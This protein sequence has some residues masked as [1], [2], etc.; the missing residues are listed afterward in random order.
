M[1]ITALFLA[2]MDLPNNNNLEKF[3]QTAFYKS[4]KTELATSWDR[5]QKTNLYKMRD[6]WDIKI[7]QTYDKDI[8][9]PFSGPD[10]MNILAFF[11]DGDTYTM[12]GLEPVGTVPNPFN[13]TDA[14]LIAG[15]KTMRKS[16]NTI[17]RANF[18]ITGDMAKD[19]KNNSFNGISAFLMSFLAKC[20]YTVIEAKNIAINDQSILVPW[21]DSDAKINWGNPPASQRIPGVEI[22]FKKGTGKTQVVRYFNVNVI[23]ENLKNRNQNFIPYIEKNKSYATMIKSASYLMHNNIKYNKIRSTILDYSCFIIQD[24]SGIPL[25][26]FKNNEWN[27]SLHGVYD[28]PI[29][30]FSYRM[31]I[32]LKE[33]YKKSTGILAFH[34]GYGHGKKSNLLTAKKL[35]HYNK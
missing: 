32:D 18:F 35:N 15:L 14:E 26:Y 25:K 20:N 7:A 27:V 34:Y 1:N 2:G 31:Q 16:L 21:E 22:T 24:D 6:W 10:I 8:F 13:K 9:Y 5:F 19:I 30:K 11:P 33:A 29:S 28:K 12:F 17:L 4:Y 23:D 3:T